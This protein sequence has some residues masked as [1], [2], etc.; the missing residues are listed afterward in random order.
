M[1]NMRFTHDTQFFCVSAS[2][3]CNHITMA[4]YLTSNRH[5]IEKFIHQAEDGF[6][7]QHYFQFC[8]SLEL[9]T[10]IEA[11]I[12]RTRNAIRVIP[13]NFEYISNKLFI[14]IIFFICFRK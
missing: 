10:N 2:R 5:E 7:W 14:Q 6:Q 4:D 11:I 13:K 1:N 9:D 3:F 12:T 8:S